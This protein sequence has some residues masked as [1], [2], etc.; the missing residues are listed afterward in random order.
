VSPIFAVT[1]VIAVLATI[2]FGG[3][4]FSTKLIEPKFDKLNPLSGLK[5]M[6][7][8]KAG[9]ELGKAI[10]K[11]LVVGGL[12]AWVLA[13]NI[14]TLATLGS[15]SIEP[16]LAETG[17]LITRSALIVAFGLVLIALVDVPYQYFDFM[18]R[19][20]MSRQEI[21]DEMK[22]MEGQPEVK[23]QIRKRQREIATRKMMAKVKDADVVITNPDHFAVALSYDPTSDGAPVLIAK[24]IDHLAFRIRDEARNNGVQIFEAPPLARSLYYTT[25]LDQP[26]PEALYVPVAQV[27]AYVFSLSSVK[28]GVRPMQR[29]NPSVPSGMR[30]DVDGRKEGA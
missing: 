28:P 30:F 14:S 10:A 9:F 6:F 16:A 4:N 23:A 11:C 24:G 21:K 3:L 8:L 22:D 25:D 5:R 1:L 20:R 27:I 19:M 15:M 2:A 7:G 26:V 17:S 18:K 29:P 12:L 13:D